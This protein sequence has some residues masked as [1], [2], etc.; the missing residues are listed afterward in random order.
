MQPHCIFCHIEATRVRQSPAHDKLAWV[1]AQ[2]YQ[3]GTCRSFA[4]AGCGAAREMIEIAYE[5]RRERRYLFIAHKEV[6][7]AASA[8]K[9][10]AGCELSI[11]GCSMVPYLSFTTRA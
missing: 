1:A 11:R 10:L 6:M 5:H 4:N 7:I 3:Q 2:Q 8:A 9:R